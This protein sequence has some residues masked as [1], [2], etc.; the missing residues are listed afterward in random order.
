[1]IYHTGH[2]IDKISEYGRFGDCLFFSCNIYSMLS[3]PEKIYA[4]DDEKLNFIE[5]D[6]V[7][8]W[9]EEAE[10]EI[11]DLMGCDDDTA[12]KILKG[13][14]QVHEAEN[15]WDIQKIQGHLA[16]RLGFDGAIAEDE[17]GTCYIIPMYNRE[18]L[19]IDVTKE[20]ILT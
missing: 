10:K 19:L 9:D 5:V 2:K 16:R 18:N 8:F 3:N 14:I 20:N 13:L 17:Q 6:N 12:C 15:S 4:V 11:M 7:N 1:M